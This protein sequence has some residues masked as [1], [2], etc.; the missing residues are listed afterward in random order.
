MKCDIKE[1]H[2]TEGPRALTDRDERTLVRNFL[3]Q[4]GLSLN[5]ALKDPNLN[6]KGV[7]KPTMRR[8]LHSHNLIPKTSTKGREISKKN[9]RKR[10]DF[11]LKHRNWTFQ[12]WSSVIFSDESDLFPQRT[13]SSVVWIKKGT[14]ADQPE[15]VVLKKL[16]IKVWGFIAANGRR[17]IVQY[18]GTM[19]QYKYKELLEHQLLG[20]LPS[21]TSQ[22]EE[23]IFM[24]DNA[25]CHTAKSV[26]SFLEENRVNL[27]AW[28]GQSPDLNPLE[29][30]WAQLQQCLLEKKESVE[31]TE[32]LWEETKR[33]FYNFEQSYIEKLYNSLPKRINQVIKSKGNRI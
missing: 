32:D 1:L 30:V 2:R 31:D 7:S 17:K 3:T 6:P 11:A 27:L 25:P 23:V 28:P 5:A 29:N 14:R 18:S 20:E 22:D 9:R 13:K 21:I 10:L 26:Q 24:Q 15:E 12:Q 19:D 16:T 8:A 33:I 4:P